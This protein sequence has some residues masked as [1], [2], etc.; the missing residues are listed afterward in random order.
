MGDLGI[1]RLAEADPERLA[2]VGPDG[3]ERTA[4]QLLATANQVANGLRALGLTTGDTV[5][6]L[7]PNSIELIEIYLGALQV[8]LYVTPINFHLVGPEVAYILTDTEAK[9]F[10]ASDRF[11]EVAVNAVTEAGF[12][13]DA[14]FSVGTIAGFRPVAELTDGQP[15]TAP[16]GR[17]TGA[18]MHYTSG[19]TGR[20]KGVKRGLFEIDPSDMGELMTMLPGLFGVGAKDDHVHLT[21]SPLYHTAVLMWTGCALHLGH[22][23]V[24]MDKWTG[25]ETLRLIDTY[26]VTYS[27]MVPTQFVRLLDLPEET[28][29]KYDVSTLRNMI[30]GAAPCPQEVKHNMIDWWGDTIQEYYAATEGG[31][32]IITAKEWQAKPGSVGLPWPGS[33]IRIYD[34]EANQ[35]GVGE[36]GTVYM[37]LSLSD[38]EYKGDSAKTKANRIGNF[39][40]VGD[41]GELDADGYLFLRDRKS[42]MIISGGVNIYPAE[43]ES[44]LLQHPM[45]GDCAVFGIPDEAMGEAIKAAVQPA[46]GAVAGPELEALLIAHCQENLAKYKVP[47]SIDFLDDFPRD[48]SGKVY[49]RTLRDPYWAGRSSQLV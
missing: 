2:L 48:P 36:I 14:S 4:G 9:A 32:T 6:L 26:K 23:V 18:A 8:G 7:L 43:T 25:E 31:G 47:R 49:K 12:P 46:E 1:W 29:A 22:T 27:H 30:H 37:S 41:L 19:T 38:F 20:P 24:L 33:E 35:L 17:T 5:A 21:V 34:D 39:F 44:V 3:T 42:D 45:V 28:R 10:I 11:A 15:T 16:E 40:T 13:A